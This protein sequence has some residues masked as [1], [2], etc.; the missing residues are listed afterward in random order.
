MRSLK[1]GD[2]CPCCGQ[3]IR[4]GLPTETMI[5]LSWL[6]EGK[7]LLEA[8]RGAGNAQW[9]DWLRARFEQGEV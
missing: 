3:P 9:K 7:D 1:P 4:E 6:Q 5:L 2:P 8:A